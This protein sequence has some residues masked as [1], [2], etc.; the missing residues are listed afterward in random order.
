VD[1]FIRAMDFRL[2]DEEMAKIGEEL[3]ESITLI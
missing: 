3:P 2:S 1:G